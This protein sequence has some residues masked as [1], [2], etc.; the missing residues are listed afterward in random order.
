[1]SS[2]SFM[3]DIYKIK[4][5]SQIKVI[6]AFTIESVSSCFLIH[7]IYTIHT[8]VVKVDDVRTRKW[9]IFWILS[10]FHQYFAQGCLKILLEVIHS[11]DPWLVYFYILYLFCL[12]L[13]CQQSDS[14]VRLLGILLSQGYSE[15]QCYVENDHNLNTL[16]W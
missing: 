11:S 7:Y 14:S 5:H 12:V 3:C 8:T 9:N 16:L 10:Y 4:K 6:L 1:M 13:C 15:C 2:P